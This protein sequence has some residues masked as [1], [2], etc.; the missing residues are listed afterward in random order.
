MQKDILGEGDVEEDVEMDKGLTRHQE[1]KK[2]LAILDTLLAKLQRSTQHAKD[3][4][5]KVLSMA[6][7]TL[8]DY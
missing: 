4:Y 8:C 7:S 1:H 5:Q 6:S 2:L 3:A